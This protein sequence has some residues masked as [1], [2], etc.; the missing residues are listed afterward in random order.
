MKSFLHT[1][2]LHSRYIRQNMLRL[3]FRLSKPTIPGVWL[4]LDPFLFLF[5]NTFPYYASKNSLFYYVMQIIL[6]PFRQHKNF[7]KIIAVSVKEVSMNK[8]CHRKRSGLL[9]NYIYKEVS[10]KDKFSFCGN[11]FLRNNIFKEV[12]QKENFSS[13]DTSLSQAL[14][15]LF[16]TRFSEIQGK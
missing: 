3:G 7:K 11:G 15:L 1:S 2:S 6:K 8:K 16:Q 10:H 5:L 12:P 14:P 9:R 13:C 4:D